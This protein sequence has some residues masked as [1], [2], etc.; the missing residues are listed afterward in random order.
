MTK[1]IVGVEDSAR[2][3]DA[4]AFADQVAA[5]CGARLILADAYP[6]ARL[7]SRVV[8]AEFEALLHADA[9]VTLLRMRRE[10]RSSDVET[11]ALPDT[12]PAR[13]L[14]ELAEDED[15]DL[16]VVGSSGR[17]DVGRV[18]A[19]TTADRLLHGSPCPVAVV[20]DGFRL[21][22]APIRNVLAAFDGSEQAKDALHAAIAL[23]RMSSAGVRL[24]Q[25]VE[26]TCLDSLALTVGAAYLVP[27]EELSRQA[28]RELDA[29]LA[30]IDG[31]D[32]V[33]AEVV[34]GDAV[35]ELVRRS[36][37][38]DLLVTGSRGYGPHRAVLLGSVSRRLVREAACP[39]LVL[40]RGRRTH[41]EALLATAIA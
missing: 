39:V 16:I 28:R 24:L 14:H 12:S 11:R 3:R 30:R 26:R 32:R 38:A 20:P 15:A 33:Q 1:I 22:A 6:S 9:E 13:A 7:P 35:D 40:P 10:A 31:G 36:E 19:G 4:V 8:S 25:V 21:H 23:A 5:T 17:G 37:N 18:L 29:Q 2:S 27:P 34:H 41:F